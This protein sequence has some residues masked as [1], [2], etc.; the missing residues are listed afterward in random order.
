MNIN[1]S[2]FINK[3]KEQNQSSFRDLISHQEEK[4]YNICYG[5]LRNKEDAEDITQEV[6]IQIYNTISQFRGEASIETWIYRIAVNRSLNQIK[7]N[8]IKHLFQDIDSTSLSF[9]N[10]LNSLDIL[11]QKQESEIVQKEIDKLPK[12]QKTAFT[13]YEYSGYSYAQIAEIMKTSKSAVESLLHRA[14]Q[15]LRKQIE[16]KLK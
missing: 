15:S 6:F 12:K 8:K 11:T 16:K 9:G 10:D 4:I 2:D 3:L 7:R 5:F 13:L 14:R 1:D